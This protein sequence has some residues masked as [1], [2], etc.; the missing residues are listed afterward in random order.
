VYPSGDQNDGSRRVL[1][2]DCRKDEEEHSTPLLRLPPLCADW[3]A[4]WR[5]HAGGGLYSTS[6]L[7]ETFDIVVLTTLMSAHI[8]LDSL[9]HLP[10]RIQLIRFLHCPTRR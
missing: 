10:S 3:C 5:C 8:A 9:W 7:A 4:F 2:R 6:C 1:N